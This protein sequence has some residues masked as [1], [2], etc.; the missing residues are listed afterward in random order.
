MTKVEPVKAYG[1]IN[2]GGGLMPLAF[3]NEND[4]AIEMMK[5]WPLRDNGKCRVIP[6]VITPE[7][8]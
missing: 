4:A 1:I 3:W 8:E 6:V 5:R 7:G 2:Y